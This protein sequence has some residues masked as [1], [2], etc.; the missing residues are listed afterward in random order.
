MAERVLLAEAIRELA[1]DGGVVALEGFTH[2]IPHAAGHE[3]IRHADV[4]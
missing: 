3:P 1:H 2:L 4:T